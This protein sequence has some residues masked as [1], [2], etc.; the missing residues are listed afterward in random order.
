MVGETESGVRVSKKMV[1]EIA[2][3]VAVGGSFV[4]ISCRWDDRRHTGHS[5]RFLFFAAYLGV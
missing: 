3:V 5:L 4:S 2:R 1:A